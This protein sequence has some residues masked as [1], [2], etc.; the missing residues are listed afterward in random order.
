VLLYLDSPS[1]SDASPEEM[2]ELLD[3]AS[4]KHPRFLFAHDRKAELLARL[5][6]WEEATEACKPKVFDGPPPIILRGRAAW[7]EYQR[8]RHD[9]AISRMEEIIAEEPDY[10]WGWQQLATWYE[11]D[12]RPEKF[13]EAAEQLVRLAPRDPS[14][15][16]YRGEARRANDDREGAKNDFVEAFDMDPDYLLAGLNLL[17]VQLEDD[18]LE[19]AAETLEE[20]QSRENDAHIR[21]RAI[22]LAAKRG[23]QS[24]AMEIFEEY[25]SD[26]EASPAIF[27]E[28]VAA[29]EDAGWGKAVDRVLDSAI[30]LD[31]SAPLVGRFWVERRMAQGD[32]TCASKFDALLERGEIGE[33]ALI[34]YL[35]GLGQNKDAAQ[36]QPFVE[37]YRD[38]LAEST[39]TWGQVG[40][41]Y[42]SVHQFDRTAE[43]MS[44]W[45]K[46][47]DAAS[48]M[49][50]NLAIA[51]RSLKRDAEAREVSEFA[52]KNAEADRTLMYHSVWLAFDDA[53]AGRIT[54]AARRTA[55]HE[56]DGEQ[57]DEYFRVVHALTRALLLVDRGGRSAFPEARS[58]I[59]RTAQENQ[60]LDPDPAIYHAWKA[61][62]SRLGRISNGI[63][64][65][66]WARRSAKNPPLPPSQ[67]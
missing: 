10:Y 49:L 3:K 63:G 14:A 58:L 62:V 45:R 16:V 9:L 4:S 59:E 18:E 44:D 12:D 33:Q 51:L 22:R 21:L 25:A 36:L 27:R 20:L 46:R 61:C 26:D 65:W 29:M 6:R 7:I 15:Y 34:A 38:A 37:K 52:L 64:A 5:E 56:K 67:P 47:D 40:W 1:G 17:D 48:W 55:Q 39:A 19:A 2:L 30:D 35:D 50:L 24:D 28:A 57:L 31:S 13:L 42:A 43:W 11:D 32:H 66:L 23:E 41:A 53:L 60:D 54:E 8:G